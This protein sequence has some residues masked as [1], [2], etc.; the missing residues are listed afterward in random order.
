MPG[1]HATH[2]RRQPGRLRRRLRRRRDRR[3]RAARERRATGAPSCGRRALP[4]SRG[5][6]AGL[7]LG[8]RARP[9]RA[10]DVVA[11]CLERGP[12]RHAPPAST[13]LRL[14]PPLTVSADEVAQ[15]ISILAG[16]SRMTAAP[17]R[18]PGRDPAPDPRAADRRPRPS[19]PTR[20]ARPGYDAVQTTVSRDIAE[21]G[22]VKVRDDERPARLRAA[23]RR[24]PRPAARARRPPSAAGRSRSRPSDTLVVVFTPRGFAAALA[25]GDRRVQPS[26]RARHASRART[27]SSS[28][29]RAG[30]ARAAARATSSRAPTWKEQH[31]QD[32]RPRLLGRARHELHH[33]LAEGGLRLRRGRRRARRRRPGVRPRAGA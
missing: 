32:G 30:V 28:S 19:S 4:A 14:T 11:A 15:A 8:A 21:L 5:A 10:A 27:R 7:L 18:A 26:R 33:R 6:R 20:C 22:L 16:G 1:D 17:P 25:R 3:R 9:R 31:E 24:R 12:A 23:R 13:S 29:A 2:L